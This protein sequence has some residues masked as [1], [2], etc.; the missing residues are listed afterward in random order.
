[1]APSE[2][3]LL[4]SRSP[5]TCILTP[6]TD[7]PGLSMA[8]LFNSMENYL[9]T[10]VSSW[11]IA[12]ESLAQRFGVPV[13]SYEGGQGLYPYSSKNPKLEIQAQNDPG[14]YTLY[15]NLITMWEKDIGT[16]FSSMPSMTATGGCCRCH[17]RPAPKSGTQ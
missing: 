11:L 1:M 3:Q 5:R 10:D 12:N 13:I 6:G 7:K 9:D 14:M 8:G 2:T 15:K 4:T 16:Q 17:R